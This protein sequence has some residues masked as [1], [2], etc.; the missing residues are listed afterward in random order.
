M[1]KKVVTLLAINIPLA[2]LAEEYLCTHENGVSVS[3]IG[4]Y[5]VEPPFAVESLSVDT[6]S[7]VRWLPHWDYLGKCTLS[8]GYLGIDGVLCTWSGDGFIRELFIN[9]DTLEHSYSVHARG[10]GTSAYTGYCVKT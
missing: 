9:S 7:G 5:T 10:N 1:I 2:T 3:L 8:Q 4:A 6:E